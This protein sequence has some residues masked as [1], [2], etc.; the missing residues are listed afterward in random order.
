VTVNSADDARAAL[1]RGDLT[2]LIGTPECDWLDAKSAPYK[3]GNPASEAELVKDVVELANNQGGLLLIGFTAQK[4]EDGREII[5]GVQPFEI[6]S[7]TVDSYRMRLRSKVVPLIQ[8]LTVR[9]IDA[10]EGCVVLVID[11]PRQVNASKP[12]TMP[13]PAV[14]KLYPSVAVPIRDGDGTHW[15]DQA[16]LQ[17]L[18]AL[19]LANS[20]GRIE[21]L[22]EAV[23]QA[24][25]EAADRA[26]SSA[27]QKIAAQAVSE[28]AN[29]SVNNDSQRITVGSGMPGYSRTFGALYN[30]V[31]PSV[32]GLPTTPAD[33]QGPVVVQYFD[34]S[35]LPDYMVM[36]AWPSSAP[37]A[38]P[39][40]VWE[41][42]RTAG[43][44]GGVE[45]LGLPDAES[46][47][48][49]TAPVVA[50]DATEVELRGGSLG[51]GRLIRDPVDLSWRWEPQPQ[52]TLSMSG[53]HAWSGR[54]FTGLRLRAYATLPLEGLSSLAIDR[55]GRE[56]LVKALAD[57][58]L[59]RGLTALVESRGAQMELGPWQLDRSQGSYQSSQSAQ[60]VAF[61]GNSETRAPLAARVALNCPNAM[62]A[63]VTAS[64]EIRLHLGAW[65]LA[66]RSASASEEESRH[67]TLHEVLDLLVA[68][69]N[70]ATSIAPLALTPD[71]AC[72]PLTGV[73]RVE[74]YLESTSQDMDATTPNL[75]WFIDLSA[76]GDP[77]SR[78]IPLMTT[79]VIAPVRFD[80][81]DRRVWATNALVAMAHNFGY[82]EADKEKL[83][84]QHEQ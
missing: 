65:L 78:G 80:H 41:A 59:S 56:R 37:V 51:R 75:D 20:G 30:A 15:L 53:Q 34:L 82:I 39:G 79:A 55:A 19:G 76:F 27:S 21:D 35:S 73:P 81:S 40:S 43:G 77:P 23:A 48:A 64:V 60:Y 29:R 10:G 44:G 25:S 38:M 70:A 63:V 17:R 52:V 67:I 50:L 26:V 84:S 61:M 6:K 72:G 47:P 11:V 7:G 9:A 4:A 32:L 46:L 42:L 18:L 69:W 3:A 83:G 71:A 8:D 49:P 33:W 28:A 57:S 45:A 66:L 14:G 12:F 1:A 62:R 24:A 22:V 5:D 2:A 16:G 13:G 31:G 68:A 74:F 58:E 36:C 54:P